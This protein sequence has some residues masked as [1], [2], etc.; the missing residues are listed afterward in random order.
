MTRVSLFLWRGSTLHIEGKALGPC[1]FSHVLSGRPAPPIPQPKNELSGRGVQS[2]MTPTGRHFGQRS[3]NENPFG[4]AWMRQDKS[5]AHCARPASRQ[6]KPAIVEY[7]EIE[8]A[9]APTYR[10]PAPGGALDGVKPGQKCQ[11]RK[12][13]FNGRN[14]V[15]EVRLIGPTERLGLNKSRGCDEF[16]AIS[17]QFTQRAHHSLTW[18]PPRPRHIGSQRHE[19][20]DCA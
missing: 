13:G 14:G 9:W 15:D 7:V 19:Y 8:C 18:R 4:Y 20:H 17:V 1:P 12:M 3:Q 5:A 10:P 6:H 2:G 16:E 11:R